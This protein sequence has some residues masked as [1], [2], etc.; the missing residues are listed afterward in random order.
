[1]EGFWIRGGNILKNGWTKR[2]E[3]L[4]FPPWRVFER[5]AG[6][7]AET[8]AWRRGPLRREIILA[9]KRA[10]PRGQLSREA[11]SAAGFSRLPRALCRKILLPASSPT[12]PSSLEAFPWRYFLGD[13]SAFSERR[14]SWRAAL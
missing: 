3:E 10:Q 9:A 1:M 13:V 14:R 7:L 4:V 2:F 12:Q 11:S 8:P 5:V 6:R